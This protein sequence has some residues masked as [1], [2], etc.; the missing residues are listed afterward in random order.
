MSAMACDQTQHEWAFVHMPEAKVPEP[1]ISPHPLTAETI[2]STC[3]L[4]RSLTPPN[5]HEWDLQNT[6]TKV[7]KK[8]TWRLH[9]KEKELNDEDACRCQ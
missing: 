9:N 1:G 8:Q 4:P 6:Q 3:T 5:D 7:Q 2:A